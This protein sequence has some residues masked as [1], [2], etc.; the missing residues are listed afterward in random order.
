MPSDVTP[1]PILVIS[2]EIAVERR[3]EITAQMRAAGL[4]FSFVDAVDGR[5]SLP[6]EWEPMIDRQGALR[7][8][9][10]GMS[11]GEFACALSHQLAYARILD[12]GLPGAVVLEDDAILTPEFAAF[13]WQGKYREADFIQLFCFAARLWRGRGRRILPGVRLFRLAENPFGNVGYSLSHRAASL[14]RDA[15]KPLRARA[16]WPADLT[17][18]GA[19]LTVPSILRHPPPA[20]SHS[21]IGPGRANVIPEGFDYSAK[22]VKGWRRLITPSC[23]VSF[24]RRRLSRD[25]NP[26]F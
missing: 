26:G 25:I 11:D 17:R 3:A 24:V 4:S 2:L 7:H 12:Q 22:Y 19:M 5:K 1:W 6:P 8:Y 23:W 21:Y 15:A 9:G 18:V 16:D 14:L 13:Y 20:Q 10:Y